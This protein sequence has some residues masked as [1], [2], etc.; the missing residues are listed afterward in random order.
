MAKGEC[1]RNPLRYDKFGQD[2]A[3]K[4]DEARHELQQKR[5]DERWEIRETKGWIYRILLPI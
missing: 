1:M 5:A 4:A 2:K 3:E